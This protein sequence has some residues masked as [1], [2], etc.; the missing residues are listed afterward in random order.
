MIK[1]KAFISFDYDHDLELKNALLAQAKNEDS[2]FEISDF[3]IKE[4]IASNWKDYARKRIKNCDVVIFI[5][6]KYTDSA[7][8]VSAEMSITQEEKQ[9]Y[10]LLWGRPDEVVQKPKNSKKDDKIYR[11]SWENLKKLIN[12]AR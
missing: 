2:P 8:G 11:W 12:G 4:A 5:C 7:T 9:N 1:K 6:G 3:S 10:F